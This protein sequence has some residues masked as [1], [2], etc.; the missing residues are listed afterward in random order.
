[1]RQDAERER[2]EA[3]FTINV[4]E[5]ERLRGSPLPGRSEWLTRDRVD[6][7]RAAEPPSP[8]RGGAR[9]ESTLGSPRR[10]AVGSRRPESTL[11]LLNLGDVGD[12]AITAVRP[13]RD[14]RTPGISPRV[15]Q[16]AR[17]DWKPGGASVAQRPSSSGAMA[18]SRVEA[19]GAAGA[20][21]GISGR[22]KA[23]PDAS[24]TVSRPLQQLAIQRAVAAGQGG[25]IRKPATELAAD[26][27]LGGSQSGATQSLS[28][29]VTQMRLSKRPSG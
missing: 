9:D 13:V 3:E 6:G 12:G 17:R 15:S 10:G 11:S 14:A 5:L 24:S 18:G 22:G 29:K 28:S 7:R 8:T 21:Q 2:A 23:A 26:P 1:V 19:G 4:E 27:W 16:A 20:G 25:A